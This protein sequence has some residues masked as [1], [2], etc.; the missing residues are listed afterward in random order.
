MG[1]PSA[2]VAFWG[3]L[4]VLLVSSLAGITTAL[5][6][7]PNYTL[8]GYVDQPGLVTPMKAGVT[9]E[10]ISSASH[11]VLT[12]TTSAGGYF[13]FTTASTNGALVP[14][15]WGLWVPQ[16]THLHLGGV[17]EWA[18]APTGAGPTYQYVSAANL[19]NSG[20]Q[21]TTVAALWQ[22]STLVSG[23]VTY[24]GSPAIGATLALLDPSI[25]GYEL[26]TT[27]TNTTGQ[28]SFRAPPGT[29]VLQ[30]N[31]SAPQP[32]YN[33][34]QVSP[35]AAP[36]VVNP[37]IDTYLAQGRI[38]QGAG[39]SLV[40]NGGN[41]SLYDTTTHAVLSGPTLPGFYSVGTYPAGFTGP[42]SESFVVLVNP[43]DYGT[44]GYALTVN[45]GARSHYQDVHVP[46][47]SSPARYS[48]SLTFGPGFGKLNVSTSAVLAN[49]SVFPDLA[50]ASV[51]QLWAQLGLDF[52]SG[53]LAFNGANAGE[54]AAFQGWL[55]TQG[56]F[57]PAGQA[58]LNVNGSTY[59]QP[60]NY[61]FTAPNVPASSLD[62]TSA[63]GLS[64]NWTQNYNTT[65]S[66]T[67]GG[68][69]RVYTIA[70]NF[71]HPV[72][73]QAINYTVNL[74][75]N[76]TLAA[77]TQKP[78][79]ALIVPAGPGRTYTS[80]TLVAKGV[81][82]GQ[83]V[84]GSANFTVVRYSAI[85]AI[86]NISVANFAYSN[87]NV[88][89][90]TRANYT[91]VVG[92]GQNVTFSAQN[93][94][95]PD[96]TNG[97]LYQWN[98]GGAGSTTTQP[99]AYHTYGVAGKYLGHVI[100]TSSGGRTS[101]ANFTVYA[102][103]SA[104][105]AVI[106]SNATA[107]E[108]HT[109]GGQA[110]LLVNWSRALH[111]NITGSTSPL[112]SNLSAMGVLSDA[113]WSLSATKY[114]LTANYSAGSSAKVNSNFTVTLTGNG[115]YFTNVSIG[116]S[117]VSPFFGWWY[118][119]TL[120][121]F[122]GQGHAA[123]TTLAVLV[124]DTE[125]P[126]PVVTLQD[127]SGKNIT[128]SGLVEGA[129]HTAEVVFSSQYSSDPHNGSVVR[130][131]WWVNNSGNSSVRIWQNT[132]KSKWTFYLA[133]QVK[134]YTVNLT[135]WDRAGNSQ[136]A[137]QKLQISVNVST[138]PVLAAGNLTAPS[139]MQDGTSYTIWGNITNTVG[140]N[141]TAKDVT[142]AFYLLNSGGSGSRINVGS[143]ANVKFYNYTSAGVVNT[144]PLAT[145][146]LGS[147]AYNATVR[148]VISWT[149]GITGSYTLYLNASA[150]NMFATSTQPNVASVPVT[151][152]PNPLANLLI[153]GIIAVVVV[154]LIIVVIFLMRRRGRPSS[155]GT[156]GGSSSGA[157]KSGLE[158]GG[159]KPADDDEDEDDEA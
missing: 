123:S 8:S 81:P 40:P 24:A 47:I 46:A 99:T 100:V 2:R 98:F 39:T 118:N 125:K 141:S 156:K 86:V 143:S 18:V 80:F 148:A 158:R 65:T 41:V 84:W 62:Y 38:R 73:P 119:L 56:P 95:Y 42:G 37:V 26:N 44:V 132:T 85:S 75:A 54:V 112:A 11:Q 144:V 103:A 142:V 68:H 128:A 91:A 23:T 145:G 6:A 153:Y 16:Q 155:A 53:S 9:V 147:L 36:L 69:G 3:L 159:K 12:A 50:N 1:S 77:N 104:P 72:G 27:T 78:S 138:R 129:N 146:T 51:G 31:Y 10:L 32:L 22:L 20:Y 76:Y 60:T 127:S 82:A 88:L 134:P 57:F 94:T 113:I 33:T 117:A 52:N 133:P 83:P 92:T 131:S 139:T 89:N 64:M 15:W 5:P 13:Q 74:P 14:G 97:T 67:G 130:F 137:T 114:N 70:F 101:E 135:A 107:A 150:A 43:V 157:S 115:L 63:T 30:S 19:T 55:A 7:S 90:G 17:F 110:Y 59:G 45:S 71:R 126:V 87:L 122:D 61:T 152:N 58:S 66:V 49:D 21:M 120:R 116:G 4:V 140:K 154:A 96:G 106:T 34:T 105:T 124:R 93:S 35:G 102:G 151:L 121:L 28:Y 108:Q 25:P 29:W 79:S 111:F 48:T 149:P 109:S 136:Y